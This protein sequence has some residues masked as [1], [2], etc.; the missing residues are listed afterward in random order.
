MI[1]FK[2]KMLYDTCLKVVFVVLISLIFSCTKDYKSADRTNTSKESTTK[3]I[4]CNIL[5]SALV[6]NYKRVY[7]S[8]IE[9]INQFFQKQHKKKGFNGNVLFAIDGIPIFVKCFGVRSITSKELLQSHDAFQLASV[10]KPITAT[11]ILQLYELGKLKL[12]DTLQKF[13]PNFP[14]QYKG[15]TIHQLLSHQSG[16]FEYDKFNDREWRKNK[17]FLTFQ[18]ILNAVIKKEPYPYY[19]AGKKFDYLNFN[20]VILAQ[21]VEKVSQKSFNEY[22]Q[23]NIFKKAGMK[24]AF[25]FNAN[26]STSV[27]KKKVFGHIYRR[28]HPLDYQDGVYGD[29]GIFASVHDMLAFNQAYTKGVLIKDSTRILAENKQVKKWNSFKNYGYGWRLDHTE[30]KKKITYHNGWWKGYKSK[31]IRLENNKLTIVVL[32]NTL[33]AM[34]YSNRELVNLINTEQ[35]KQELLKRIKT[36]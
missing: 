24:D 1:L 2:R 5:D 4:L 13:I 15:I 17:E 21:I 9:D 36:N 29:K 11:A 7:K 26:D 20:Y 16:L 8:E 3:L 22:L 27:S 31:F 23:L 32:S 30:G 12:T 18:A 33:K 28:T 10:S 34:N 6:H 35:P 19:K 25:V 14:T